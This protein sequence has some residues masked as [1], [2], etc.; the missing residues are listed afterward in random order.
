MPAS[1]DMDELILRPLTGA[2]RAFLDMLNAIRRH[3]P[4]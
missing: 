2:V 3:S 4:I 1:D